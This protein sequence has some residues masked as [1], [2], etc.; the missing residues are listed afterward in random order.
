MLLYLRSAKF[1]NEFSTSKYT[2][3]T[4]TQHQK[5][6]APCWPAVLQ[7]VS[8]IGNVPYYHMTGGKNALTIKISEHSRDSSYHAYTNISI[9]ITEELLY[10]K[11]KEERIKQK[12]H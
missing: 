1:L 11:G 4:P 10:I 7:S 6:H 8:P 5:I 3:I 2:K 9:F 12:R